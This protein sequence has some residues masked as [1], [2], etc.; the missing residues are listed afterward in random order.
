MSIGPFFVR[1][2]GEG[3]FPS[4]VRATA[5][6][7]GADEFDE[8]APSVSITSG[9]GEGAT[10]ATATATFGFSSDDPT[11]AFSCDLDGGGFGPCSGPGSSH[12][13]IALVDGSH[14]FSVRATDPTGNS[15]N[16]A[17][18]FAVD[19]DAPETR[20]TKHPRDRT[21]SEKAKFKFRSDEPGATFE[22]KL[23]KR[24]FRPCTSPRRY[25][26]LDESKHRFLVRATDAAGNTDP[27]PAKD[28]WKVLD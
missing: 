8:I 7:I 2:T 13:L 22:C 17:R 27:S 18:S 25:K 12:T 14:S 28:R 3:N 5:P 19:T 21:R 23:D 24:R 11:V 4:A 26:R 16:A 9:P 10:I 6:D 15:S 1:L 20:I